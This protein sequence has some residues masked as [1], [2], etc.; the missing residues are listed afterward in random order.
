MKTMKMLGLILD[1]VKVK[2][3]IPKFRLSLPS[4][5]YSLLIVKSMYVMMFSKIKSPR[6]G[7]DVHKKEK[8]RN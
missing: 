5:N 7:D 3:G 1:P 8:K 4:L 2:N 6:E